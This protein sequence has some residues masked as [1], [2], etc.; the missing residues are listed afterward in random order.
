MIIITKF[1][2]HLRST[3]TATD[4]VTKILPPKQLETRSLTLYKVEEGG[5][6]ERLACTI[7]KVCKKDR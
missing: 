6:P 4:N 2:M 1:M 5:A 7:Y 3:S